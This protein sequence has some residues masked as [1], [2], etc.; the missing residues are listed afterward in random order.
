MSSWRS[1][2]ETNRER[3]EE[4]CGSISLSKL[5][6]CLSSECLAMGLV[7][8]NWQLTT[9][10]SR[11]TDT[12]VTYKMQHVNKPSRS[13]SYEVG[14]PRYP[15]ISPTSKL[16]THSSSSSPRSSPTFKNGGNSHHCITKKAL[17]LSILLI[18]VV[19]GGSKGIGLEI[20]RQLASNEVMAIL[21]ARDEKRGTEAV[22]NLKACGLL[23]ASI[24]SLADYIKNKFGKLDILVNNAGV[25]GVIMDAESFTSL[26]LKSGEIVGEKAEMA[27]KVI[28]QTYETAE[29]CLRTNYYGPKQLSQALIPLFR[30]SSSARIVNVSSGLGA[31]KVTPAFCKTYM[32]FNNGHY[33]A[34]Q[35]AKG[36]VK[37]GSISPLRLS[38][39][40]LL[41]A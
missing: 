34:E 33:T 12:T 14:H 2:I 41:E 31:A 11:P 26:K 32:S 29:G 7:K 19:T 3:R 39:K 16:S 28:K 15:Q 9:L 30:L 35:G 23:S 1:K 38:S 37:L 21:T 18:A 8:S 6:W 13:N 25:S 10:K 27:K 4:E 5:Y 17:S 22:E 20:C 36:P 24:A 40:R